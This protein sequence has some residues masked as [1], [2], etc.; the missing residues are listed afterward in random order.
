MNWLIPTRNITRI[1]CEYDVII[2]NS[3]VIRMRAKHGKSIWMKYLSIFFNDKIVVVKRLEG[4]LYELRIGEDMH[5]GKFNEIFRI[6]WNKTFEYLK[7]EYDMSSTKR[8]IMREILTG[9]G[10]KI[11]NIPVGGVIR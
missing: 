1:K 6:I 3:K 11:E 4:D 10:I 7:R 9:I 2:V 8:R 5:R